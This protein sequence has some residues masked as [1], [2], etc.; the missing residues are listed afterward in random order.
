MSI[1]YRNDPDLKFLQFCDKEDL[2]VLV[3]YLTQDKDGTLRF[4]EELTDDERFKKCKGDYSKIWDLI[5]GELQLFGGDTIVNMII[6]GGE[7]V[8][9]KEIL[10]DVCDKLKV[11]YNEKSDVLKI[12]NNLI[13]KVVEDTIENMSEKEKREFADDFHIDMTNVSTAGIMTALQ[14]AIKAGGFASYR[15]AMV[16]ANSVSK[17]VLG[18]GLALATNAGLAKVLSI[19]AGPIGWTISAILT[20]PAIFGTA[21]RVTIPSVLHI[22]YMRQKNLNKDIV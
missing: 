12:E 6:R 5:A 19:F 11:N 22:A 14:I 15:I 3:K 13:M 8:L 18:R 2:K 7:G 9:Y 4:A 16:V 21:Y 20:L 10:C 17:F 1:K